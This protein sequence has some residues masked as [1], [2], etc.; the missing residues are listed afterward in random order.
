[1][2]SKPDSKPFR[3]RGHGR[4]VGRGGFRGQALDVGEKQSAV[5]VGA[6]PSVVVKQ[7]EKEQAAEK[8]NLLSM[9]GEELSFWKNDPCNS[10][11]WDVEGALG[12]LQ[13]SP[14]PKYTPT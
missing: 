4:D 11:V 9:T 10:H 6:D 7:E 3:G 12:Q 13:I 14:R 2:D 8:T 1:M 5:T